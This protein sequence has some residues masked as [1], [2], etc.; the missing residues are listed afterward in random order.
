MSIQKAEYHD[1]GLVRKIQEDKP[2]RSKASANIQIKGNPEPRTQ[3]P[4]WEYRI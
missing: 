3:N 4:E 2:Q 1:T